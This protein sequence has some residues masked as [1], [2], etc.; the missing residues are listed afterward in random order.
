MPSAGIDAR[1]YDDFVGVADLSSI[2][3]CTMLLSP[4]LVSMANQD[5]LQQESGQMSCSRRDLSVHTM[6]PFTQDP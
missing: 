1:V 5:P 3:P 4:L 6:L 2:S